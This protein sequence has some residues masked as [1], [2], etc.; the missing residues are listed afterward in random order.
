M[1]RALAVLALSTVMTSAFAAELCGKASLGWNTHPEIA[2]PDVTEYC[3]SA[4][5][6]GDLRLGFADRSVAEL[7]FRGQHTQHYSDVQ[8]VM[9]QSYDLNGMFVD[10]TLNSDGEYPYPTRLPGIQDISIYTGVTG[11]SGVYR[12]QICSYKLQ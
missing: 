6:K 5:D 1:K 11:E 4:E 3:L 7:S 8:S 10:V 2:C 9:S 12:S